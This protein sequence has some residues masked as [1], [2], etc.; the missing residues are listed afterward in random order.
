MT[1]TFS[2]YRSLIVA[3]LFFGI[4]ALLYLVFARHFGYYDDDWYSMY[5]ARV[6]GPDIFY[7]F[8]Q[9]DS[10]PARALV[11][12][13][14]YILFQGNPLY[15]GLSAYLLRVLGALTM[16]WTL[17]LVWPANKRETFIAALLFLVYPGYLSQPVVIDFQS[18]MVGIWMAFL[19][20]G[21]SI[22]AI[23]A[24]GR[25]TRLLL[26]LGTVASGLFYISQMEYYIGFEGVRILLLLAIFLR[27]SGD[28]RQ[29]ARETFKAWLPYAVIPVTFLIW[30]LFFFEGQ[31][32]VTD[33]ALQLGNLFN[34]PIHTILTWLVLFLQDIVNVTFLAWSVP[35]T[36]LGFN[37]RLRDSLIAL[38]I[39]VLILVLFYP[40]YALI[41]KRDEEENGYSSD[42]S[43]E[44]L[45]VGGVWVV[46]G[47]VFV[48]IANRHVVFPEFS[49]Y[50]FVSAGGAVI[51]ITAFLSQLS[52]KRMQAVIMGMLLVSA[53]ITH[54]GN[55]VRFA[56][57]FDYIRSFWWQVS[58]R[59]PN[60]A[61]G[62]TIIAHYPAGGIR[63]TSFVW[64]P[65]NQIY[66]PQ[67]ISRDPVRTGVAAMLLDQNTLID[68]LNG[69]NQ[70]SDLYY[71]VESYPDPD[72]L[73]ILTQPS[74]QSCVQVIDGTAPEY[75]IHEDPII[76]MIGSDSK[77]E[78]IEVDSPA[79]QVP[80]FLF[81]PEP[82][83][84]WCYYY[85]KAVLARQ[86][87]DWDEVLRLGREAVDAGYSP[88]DLIEWMPFLQAY[89]MAGEEKSL[90]RLASIV[91]SDKFVGKQACQ[92]LSGMQG[93]APN[94]EAV[95]D[96]RYCNKPAN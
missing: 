40:V 16:L 53:T 62:T 94:I 19:S 82:P 2:R 41:N 87:G 91:W 80:E 39:A 49:R 51:F 25:V 15:Y 92:L 26:W 43:R 93:L 76:Q 31:R 12:I 47:L 69:R 13:P 30:R 45:W 65:A 59:V 28:W 37:M 34:V 64:G 66:Y 60:L 68:V 36:Q 7:D 83:H 67:G 55:A 88:E 4:G 20:L 77:L 17:R 95:I 24:S 44:G 10:R 96:D 35:L 75:S 81:G 5:A 9:R 79:P 8:Y 22:K 11:M 70:Y 21:L 3:A 74:A 89:A 61:E 48:I 46:L 84:D 23:S 27:R 85:E 42:F 58:W 78:Q 63:E 38:G 71:L 50:G 90:T 72:R 54:Y 29:G 32:K 73:I 86:N 6:A 14:L 33:V 18:H 57:Q 52:S 1:Y 56:T